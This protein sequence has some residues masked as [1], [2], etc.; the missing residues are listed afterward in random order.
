MNKLFNVFAVLALVGASCSKKEPAPAPERAASQAVSIESLAQGE[1]PVPANPSQGEAG[2]EGETPS[3]TPQN[4]PPV[5]NENATMEIADQALP[6]LQQAVDS[7][8]RETQRK[9]TNL[10]QLVASRHLTAVPTPPAGKKYV[11]DPQ[12]LLVKSVKK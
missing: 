1:A 10:E 6:H 9:P 8:Y 5:S 12:S 2:K 3:E 4:E 11:I 7:Y